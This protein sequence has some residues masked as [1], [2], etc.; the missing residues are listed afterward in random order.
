MKNI[1]ENFYHRL[2][3]FFAFPLCLSSSLFHSFSKI[4]LKYE[5]TQLHCYHF[6]APILVRVK[7]GDNEK[8]TAVKI[9]LVLTW[10]VLWP[11]KSAPLAP[12]HSGGGFCI[13]EMQWRMLGWNYAYTPKL[14]VVVKYCP[15][16]MSI[17]ILHCG[18]SFR[19][20]FWAFLHMLPPSV[21]QELSEPI[22]LLSLRR[23]SWVN[24]CLWA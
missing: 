3:K 14:P 6:S 22:D 20:A 17:C 24:S 2:R 7:M 12:F 8:H 11:G 1:A 19:G 21:F 15:R 13:M 18:G 16:M 23:L 10:V 4:T 5:A 9:V